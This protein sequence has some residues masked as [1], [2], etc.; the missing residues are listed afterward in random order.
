MA[1][2]HQKAPTGEVIDLLTGKVVGLTQGTGVVIKRKLTPFRSKAFNIT[3]HAI[4]YGQFSKTEY[5]KIK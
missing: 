3:G 2:H 1:H 4:C 5:C